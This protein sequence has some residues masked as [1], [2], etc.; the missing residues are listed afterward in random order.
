MN[1]DDSVGPV[2]E[3]PLGPRTSC[4]IEVACHEIFDN[5][6]ILRLNQGFEI[7]RIQIAALFREVSALVED[8]GDAA[9]H[10]CGKIS[11]AGSEDQHKSIRHVLAAMIAHAFDDGGRSGVADRKTFSSHAVEEG[12]AAGRAVESDIA[13]DNVFLR[14]RSANLG[15]IDD[16]SSARTDPCRRNRWLRL[17][18]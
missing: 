8:V 18:E 15:R 13:D 10:A 16:Q 9:A 7:D 1:R 4:Q 14:Q 3:N 17:P 12:F 11:S 5:L 2:V 6:Q